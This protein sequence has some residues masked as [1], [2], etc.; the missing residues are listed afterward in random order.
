MKMVDEQP[1]AFLHLIILSPSSESHGGG[2][3]LPP[4]PVRAWQQQSPF[5]PF[6]CRSWHSSDVGGGEALGTTAAAAV[7]A[8]VEDA[9]AV[10]ALARGR[11]LGR[12][13][14]RRATSKEY[15]SAV[16]SSHAHTKEGGEPQPSSGQP[17]RGFFLR[18]RIDEQRLVHFCPRMVARKWLNGP[19]SL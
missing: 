15:A 3:C 6:M 7:E 2:G 1:E 10:E 14:E 9:T 16:R 8:I 4:M 18:R 17:C 12:G 5:L 11:T 19:S 13:M